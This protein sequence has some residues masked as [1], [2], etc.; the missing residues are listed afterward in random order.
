MEHQLFKGVAKNNI[1]I[2]QKCLKSKLSINAIHSNYSNQTALLLACDNC[3]SDIIKLL[4][5]RGADVTSKDLDG[6]TPLNKICK[7]YSYFENTSYLFEIIQLLL[8][9][10]ADVNYKNYDGIT[11]FM[12]ACSNRI[13]TRTF[14]LLIKYSAEI[15]ATDK[16]GWT[17]LMYACDACSYDEAKFLLENGADV[18]SR[19]TDGNTA[20]IIA[21]G[22]NFTEIAKLL[23]E[24]GADVN[25]RNTD[26]NTALILLVVK[27]SQKL[28]NYY[29]IIVLMLMIK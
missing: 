6:N 29:L 24:N 3:K 28:P 23:L 14:D 19:K 18:N 5:E 22:E 12:T 15:N 7:R 8:E 26:G 1:D 4:L 13:E 21:C 2:V 9:H 10:G 16:Y 11:P 20:L 27:I 25:S 17:P